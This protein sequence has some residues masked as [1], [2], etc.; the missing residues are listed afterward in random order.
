VTGI[1]YNIAELTTHSSVEAIITF[2]NMMASS[3][4]S[5][6]VLNLLYRMTSY[7]DDHY[8]N[9]NTTVERL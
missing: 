6:N 1:S 7:P 5:E 3:I 2:V 4:E 9:E 8:V